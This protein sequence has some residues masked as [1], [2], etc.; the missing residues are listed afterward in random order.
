MGYPLGRGTM[1]I[2]FDIGH[3]AHV[4]LFKNIIKKLKNDGHFIKITARDKEVTLALLNAYGLEYESRGSIFHGIFN[5]AFGM[6]KIDWTLFLIAKTFHP[7]ILVGVHNPYIAHVGT[8]LRKP[9]VIFTDT[10]NVKI[11]S[12]VTYPFVKCIITPEYF[13]E[14]IDPRKHVKVNGFKETA[15][16]HPNY[17]TPD[18]M[19]IK[20]L[21]LSEGESF[22]ILRFISWGA[23]HDIGLQGIKKEEEQKIIRTLSQYG[24]I[25]ITSEKPLS[26]ELER[27][28]LNIPA[29]K[30]HSLLSFARLYIGEGGTMAAEAAFL[31]TPAIHIESDKDGKPTGESCGNFLELRDKYQLIYFYARPEEALKKAVEIL[32]NTNSRMEWQEKRKRLLANVVDVTAWMTRFIEEFPESFYQA[33]MTKK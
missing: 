32:E 31:G 17:F 4:H 30:I 7:D 33:A 15:Y 6:L 22:I 16:L 19:V 3:P 8:L 1:R 10:E 29:H 9:A 20:E 12:L 2:L 5:K 27:Y 13:K 26:P 24:R 25:F 28:R 18:P 21:G 23:S 11:A 14:K